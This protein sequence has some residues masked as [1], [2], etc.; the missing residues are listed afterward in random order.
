VLVKG[1]DYQV[2]QV[3]GA[4]AVLKNGG[5]VKMLSFVEGCSTS[6]IIERIKQ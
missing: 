1:G 4:Q 3:A 2:E 6:K 5:Q